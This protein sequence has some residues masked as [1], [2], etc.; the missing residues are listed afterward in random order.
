VALSIKKM[1]A[2]LGAEIQGVDLSKPMD[3]A[4]FEQIK[5]AFYEHEVIY[6]RGS[7]FSDE[8][9]I[10]FSRRWGEVRKLKYN[11]NDLR[12]LSGN[13]EINVVSN[14]LDEQ[15]KHIGTYD[16]GLFWHTDGAYYPGNH[17]KTLLH[18]LEIPRDTNGKPLGDTVFASATAAYEALSESMKKRLAGLQ[19]LHSL[20]KRHEK[21]VAVGKQDSWRIA[22]PRK[23]TLAKE[24]STTEAVHPVIRPHPV[25]G[26]KCL[27]VSD[28]HTVR[29]LDIPEDE[30]ND[31]IAELTAHLVKP[32]FLYRHSWQESDLL[33]WDDNAT[34][35]KA[36]FD[37]ALPQRRV[38]HR[39]I[40][41]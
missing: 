12:T 7:E 10:R 24:K 41:L 35:H 21:T 16:S 3:D 8:D 34:Q 9:H 13:L 38:M 19:A 39:T 23:E 37:Y 15:G 1:G 32:E 6:F 2:R 26:K 28:A 25:T 22:Q 17:R 27:Y 36:T 5:Q 18:A 33:M 40:V 4:T 14:V 30:S 11:P 29:I 20:A 31:L